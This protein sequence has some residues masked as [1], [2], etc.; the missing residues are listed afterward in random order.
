[1]TQP[2]PQTFVPIISDFKIAFVTKVDAKVHLTLRDDFIFDTDEEEQAML[3]DD[4][5][6][7]EGKYSIAPCDFVKVMLR[8]Q[9]NQEQGQ[10]GELIQRIRRQTEYYFGN[11]NFY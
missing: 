3:Q 5:Y 8:S 9:K 10:G 4:K 11:K 2:D 1:M 6:L 7:G